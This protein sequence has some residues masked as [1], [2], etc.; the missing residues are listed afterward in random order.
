MFGKKKKL[1]TARLT[2]VDSLYS[3]RVYTHAFSHGQVLKNLL[4][5]Y[6]FPP[7]MIADV[8]DTVT[9]EIMENVYN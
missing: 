8:T 5:K 4:I 3:T 6:P 7:N 9:G 2:K 1:Y